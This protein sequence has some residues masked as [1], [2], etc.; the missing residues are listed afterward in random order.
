[1]ILKLMSWTRASK[2]GKKIAWDVFIYEREKFITTFCHENSSSDT[3]LERKAFF[4][5]I[6]P[7]SSFCRFYQFDSFVVFRIIWVNFKSALLKA[8]NLEN[9]FLPPQQPL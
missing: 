2:K 8:Q 3:K 9:K 6:G 7:R 1:M 5:K 4:W